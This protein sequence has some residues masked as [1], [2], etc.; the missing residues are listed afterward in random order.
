MNPSL[1]F[2]GQTALITG[3]GGD[4]GLATARRLASEGAAIALLDLDPAKLE[5]SRVQLLK[6]GASVESVVCDVTDIDAVEQAVSAIVERSGSIELLFNNAGYQGAFS[7]IH[8]HPA[9]EFD[10]VIRV[11]VVGA[12][13]V[14][15]AVS[16]HMVERGYGR[17]VNTA[18]MAGVQGPPNMAAYGA[19]KFA[20]VGLTETAAKDLAPYGIRVNAISPAFIGPGF[21]WDRQ[22]QLQAE[23][24]SQ[25]FST[26]PREVA[27]QMIDSVPMRRYGRVDE[28]PG[29]VAYLL[30]DDASYVTGINV[31]I[32]GGIN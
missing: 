31:H 22:V 21:M 1:R 17:I 15:K 29:T 3:G 7:P 32:S 12:F 18:S 4:I 11:N 6:A 19:S 27:C 13:H 26:D 8:R 9:G 28:I 2:H 23:A 16:G 24:N 10:R 5:H 14:L 30:S 20:V 25:Y